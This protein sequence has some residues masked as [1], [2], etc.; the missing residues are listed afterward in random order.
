M[1][2]AIICS[3]CKKPT[4]KFSTGKKKRYKLCDTCKKLPE[5]PI[6]EDE[7]EYDDEY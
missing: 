3:E 4:G 1:L 2:R 6:T 7:L 5:H